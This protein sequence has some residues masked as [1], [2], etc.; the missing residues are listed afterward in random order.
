MAF[1]NNLYK[2]FRIFLNK[3]YPQLFNFCERRKAIVKF[4]IAG[5]FAGTVDL[6]ALFIFHDVFGW[7]I[8]FSTS[9]AFILAFA[10]SLSLQKIWTF[11]NY[12]HKKLPRQLI[13][14][15]TGAFI[16]LNLNTLGMHWLVNNLEVWYLLSQLIVNLCLGIM[17]F[18][19]YKFIVFKVYK[20]ED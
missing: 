2:R 10:V 19:N 17:N 13:L 15:F 3:R 7:D 16:S 1:I 9:A 5:A 18:F 4:F 20:N 14:Y 6:I 8:L 12:S 11:R